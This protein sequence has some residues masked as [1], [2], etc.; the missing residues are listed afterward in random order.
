MT[1]EI[2]RQRKINQNLNKIKIRAVKAL[3]YC[4]N[5]YLNN[6][7]YPEFIQFRVPH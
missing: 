4:L 7:D 1:I 6:R 2:K 5:W 3:F